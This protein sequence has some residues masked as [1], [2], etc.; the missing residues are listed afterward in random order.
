MPL[1]NG[2][3]LGPYEIVSQLGSGGMGEVY[4]ARDS[5]L[6]RTVAIKV[7]PATLAADPIFRERFEREARSLSALSHPNICTI[8][9]VGRQSS[10]DSRQAI[11]YLVMEHLEGPTLAAILAQGAMRTEEA[12]RVAAQV[13]DALVLAHRHGIIHRDL[14]PANVILARPALSLPALS[15]PNGSKGRRTPTSGTAKL[16]DFGLAKRAAVSVAAVTGVQAPADATRAAPLTG[17]G[18]ILGTFQYMAPEQIE[19]R[20]ADART[21]IWAFGCLL[22]EML[23]GRRAFDAPTQAGLIAAIMERQPAPIVLPDAALTPGLNRLVA[24]CLEK[25]PDERFQSMR[26][27]RRE[28]E[29]IPQIAASPTDP[30]PR[31]G[32]RV[33]IIGSAAVAALVLVAAGA[34]AMRRWQPAIDPPATVAFTVA[35]DTPGYTVGPPGMF[36]GAGSGTPAVSPDGKRIAF[37][38]HSAT[39]ATIWVRD[40]SKLGPKQ[41]LGTAGA[42]GLFWSPDGASIGFFTAGKLKTIELAS[43]R[44]ETVCDAPLGFGGTWAADGTILFSP[45]ERSPIFKVSAQGGAPVA[46]T[47]LGSGNDQAHRWPHF[48]PDGRHFVFM[49]WADNMTTR[50]IQIG[51]LDG[52]APRHLFDAQSGA[53]LAGDHFL[54]VVDTPARLMA[55]PFD[56]DTMQLRGKPF[57][58]VQDDNVDYQWVTGEPSA[59]AAGTTLAYTSGKYRR[60]QLTLVSRTGRPLQTLGEP[61]I[62]FD[63]IFSPDGSAVALEKHDAGRGA[64]DIWTVDLARGAFTRVSTTPGYETTPVWSPDGRRVAYA[65]DQGARPNIYVNAASGAGEEALLVAAGSRSFPL[66]WSPDGRYLVFML[67]GGATRNDIWIYDAQQKAP[68]PLLASAFNEGWARVSPDGRW[69]AYVSDESQ[70]REVYVRSF[71]DGAVKTRISTAGGNQPQWRRDAKEL[72]YIAPDNTIMAVDVRATADRLDAS[73]P[74][75]LF[76]ANVDQNKSIR[77]QYAVSPDGQHFLILSLADR[78]ASPIVAVLN[79]RRLLTNR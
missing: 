8:H 12:L 35:L 56:T 45:E 39:D 69:L 76:A 32:R 7:L 42:R 22:Y 63:P 40:L 46:V 66:D 74:D 41:L 53:V 59:S 70:Q 43:E 11:D 48:L 16:L 62:Y 1:E 54:Y 30:S 47:S 38:A 36:G 65:S 31:R 64:G 55:W 68:R 60:T 57:P 3:R 17:A 61:A 23:T 49:G 44:V 26:D 28:L 78:N 72:F 34:L 21:D 50:A 37:I 51:S 52:S 29:W 27:V 77:N 6:D 15:L 73:R 5:R 18:T 19:G 4:A 67:N 14:K 13:A 71:P 9:D 75:P 58:L 24:A 20:E 25:N 79:W 33:V 2:T 10:A